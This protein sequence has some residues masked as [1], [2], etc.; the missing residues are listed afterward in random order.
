[1]YKDYVGVSNETSEY[2]WIVIDCNIQ[3]HVFMIETDGLGF[4]PSSS[5]YS[6]LFSAKWDTSMLTAIWYFFYTSL[7]QN[8]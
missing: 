7:N 6:S 3:C 4:G 5:N 2:Q 1:M 8:L